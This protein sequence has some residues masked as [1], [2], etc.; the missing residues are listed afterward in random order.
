MHTIWTP[1]LD[2]NKPKYRALY[3]ALLDDI[4][5]NTLQAETKLPPIRELAFALDVTPATV[6]RA[7]QMATDKGAVE[8]RKGDGTYVR[9]KAV[10]AQFPTKS[11]FMEHGEFNLFARSAPEI[12]Q[13]AFVNQLIADLASKGEFKTYGYLSVQ[14]KHEL[15]RL[16]AAWLQGD[17]FDV[18]PND[19]VITQGAD[20]GSSIA[21]LT[22]Q[23]DHPK[24][25]GLTESATYTGFLGK[26]FLGDTEIMGVEVDEN[27]IIPDAFEA[28]ARELNPRFYLTSSICANPIS[29][30]LSD[31]RF[32]AIADLA[33]RYDIEIIDDIL[34]SHLSFNQNQKSFRDYAPERVWTVTSLAKLGYPALNFGVLIPPKSRVTEARKMVDAVDIQTNQMQFPLIKNLMSSPEF[35]TLIGLAREEVRARQE[36]V[37]DALD[38]FEF[39]MAEGA[40]FLWLKVPDE[41]PMSQLVAELSKR[42]V[43]VAPADLFAANAKFANATSHIRLTLGGA[44]PRDVFAQA[45]KIVAEVLKMETRERVI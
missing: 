41:I 10:A 13:T 31:E 11:Y 38:G 35:T 17:N 34:Y 12:G 3:D 37:R 18:A 4:K 24:M 29:V 7:Y 26:Q 15:A 32:R 20:N 8:A 43:L 33:E 28:M 30:T 27:G 1:T 40:A 25:V 44:H 9:G 14:E 23:R 6:A 21:L 5:D 42:N 2:P 39:S 45:L 22:L 16:A 36:L 19:L